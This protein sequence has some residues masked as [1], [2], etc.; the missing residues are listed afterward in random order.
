LGYT[1]FGANARA[2]HVTLMEYLLY[3]AGFNR[4]SGLE[5]IG[6]AKS[7]DL[8]HWT[9]ASQLPVVVAGSCGGADAAQS[10]NPCV[11]R[12]DERFRMWYQGKS[13]QGALSVCYAESLDGVAWQVRPEAVLAPLAAGGYRY[14][15]Q[16]PHVLYDRGLGIFR[17]WCAKHEANN[18][19]I[20]YAESNDGIS[21]VVRDENVLAPVQPWEGIR[22]Y[23]PFVEQRRDELEM[24]YTGRR[25]GQLWAIGRA[26]SRDGI[27]WQ[28]D[29]ANPQLPTR[30]SSARE[31]IVAQWK[32]LFSIRSEPVFGAASPFVFECEGKRRMLTHDVGGNQRLSIG[33]YEFDDGA[34]RS[35]A[36]DILREGANEW[37]SYFQADPYLIV[38]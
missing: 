25:I 10:S 20:A 38:I 27:S 24:W 3:Y 1:R 26:M 33:M 35:I 34:W 32:A 12:E 19:M 5:Q 23:Y 36:R 6:L 18:A 17:M 22:V 4:A 21:W 11:L 7:D 13:K 14:G 9:R 30:E 29:P 28:R 15:Y 37:D 2:S 31:R 16:Q 8:V